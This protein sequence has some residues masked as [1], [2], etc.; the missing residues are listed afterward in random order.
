MFKDNDEFGITEGYDADADDPLQ[1]GLYS[2]SL[3]NAEYGQ[4]LLRFELSTED[5]G[6]NEKIYKAKFI[7]ASST[8]IVNK[9]DLG[10]TFEIT[11][12]QGQTAT[13]VLG[14]ASMQIQKIE[15]DKESLK[16]KYV[17]DKIT[18]QDRY[19]SIRIYVQSQED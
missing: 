19:H 17:T 11:N 1:N 8:G 15:K 7:K 4:Q 16:L 9:E 3:G 5:K 18:N 10:N 12:V 2:I 6:G 13:V 14:G